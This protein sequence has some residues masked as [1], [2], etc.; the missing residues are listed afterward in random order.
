MNHSQDNGAAI[1]SESD[2]ILAR[3]MATQLTGEALAVMRGAPGTT[4]TLLSTG[5]D[6]SEDE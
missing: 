3:R 4:S 6:D 2:R 5:R 1:N